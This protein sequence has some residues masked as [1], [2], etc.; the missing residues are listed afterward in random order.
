[1]LTK[2]LD[3]LFVVVV[4]VDTPAWKRVHFLFRLDIDGKQ[5]TLVLRYLFVQNL[6][7]K[8][9]VKYKHKIVLWDYTV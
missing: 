6:H 9:Y 8:I 7:V 1:M 5:N 2:G 4:V 3:V